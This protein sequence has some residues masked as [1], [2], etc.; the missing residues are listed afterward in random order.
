VVLLRPGHDERHI[1]AVAERIVEA[2]GLPF[3]LDEGIQAIVGASVGI[4]LFPRDGIDAGTLIRN[5]DIA[6]YAAKDDG[7]GQYRF[8]D[9]F[10]SGE[11]T[12]RAR[13]KAQLIGAIESDQFCLHY[14]PRVHPVSGDLLSMEALPR[15]QHPESGMVSPGDLIPLAES[16]GLI[17]RIG[18]LVIDKACAQLAAWRLSGKAPR[19]R[20]DQRVP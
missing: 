10:L 9:H 3:T 18:A 16:S 2:F 12:R 19:A 20:I 7:K 11:I 4:S 1:A 14:Q 13:L 5:A 17:L 15:W 8:F 6:M